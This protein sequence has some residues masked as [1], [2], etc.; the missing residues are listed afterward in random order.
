MHCT[1]APPKAPEAPEAGLWVSIQQQFSRDGNIKAALTWG[2]E[3]A[4]VGMVNVNAVNTTRCTG[5]SKIATVLKYNYIDIHAE[6]ERERY[7]Y[8]HIFL[9][10]YLIDWFI[11]SLID[12]L[13][14]WVSDWLIEWLIDWLIHSLIDWLVGWL[15]DWGLA[16]VTDDCHYSPLT[17]QQMLYFKFKVQKL[18]RHCFPEQ[19]SPFLDTDITLFEAR[20]GHE[21]HELE[22]FWAWKN[23]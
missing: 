10:I 12:W 7:I 5:H 4:S 11:D 3:Q 1:W 9:L 17:L 13:I 19:L 2:Y 23:P 22:T 16:G 8:I 18:P 15:I 14:E 21:L 6:R 20:H